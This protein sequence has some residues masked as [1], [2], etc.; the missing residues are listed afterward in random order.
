MSDSPRNQNPAGNQPLCRATFV[1]EVLA[2]LC[3]ALQEIMQP[4]GGQAGMQACQIIKR[5]A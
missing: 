3:Q 2:N 5:R 1:P 4:A